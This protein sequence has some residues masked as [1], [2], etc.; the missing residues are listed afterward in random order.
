MLFVTALQRLVGLLR[1][2]LL[3]GHIQ[4]EHPVGIFRPPT[5]KLG[6]IFYRQLGALA[7]IEGDAAIEEGIIVVGS[8]LQG[9]VERIIGVIEVLLLGQI[10]TDEVVGFG[11][12]GTL[13]QG[14]IEIDPR[15]GAQ[16]NPVKDDAALVV[17]FSPL[18]RIK[19]RRGEQLTYLGQRQ[20][21]L[22]THLQRHRQNSLCFIRLRGA[23]RGT[24]IHTATTVE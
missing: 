15:H 20:F 17:E 4:P 22:V 11:K 21:I 19:I 23:N 7:V 2:D 12:I 14:P 6:Q 3:L 8:E 5:V 24:S 10:D 1:I 13:T 16:P 18:I 9:G